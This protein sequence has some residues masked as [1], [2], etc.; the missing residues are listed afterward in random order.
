MTNA[1]RANNRT[2]HL[3]LELVKVTEMAALEASRWFGRGNADAAYQAATE[4]MFR[5]LE[6]L[7]IENMVVLT[8]ENSSY[9]NTN[10]KIGVAGSTEKDLII[11]PLESMEALAKGMP[12]AISVAALAGKNSLFS[13]NPVQ[14]I[15]R[16]AVG[17]AAK[18]VI[19]LNASLATNLNKVA[20]KL[21]KEISALNVAILNKQ[22]NRTTIETVRSLGAKV[23]LFDEGEIKLGLLVGLRGY[24]IDMLAGIASSTGTLISACAL[25]AMGGEMLARLAPQNPVEYT[26][27]IDANIDLER[28]LDLDTLVQ[29]QELYFA[30]TGITDSVLLAGVKYRGSGAFTHSLM[31]SSGTDVNLKHIKTEHNWNRLWQLVSNN[32]VTVVEDPSGF[33]IG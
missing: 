33:V 29:G 17:A 18:G 3:G 5:S 16:L 4:E 22:F 24:G 28:I 7:A 21:G 2:N 14:N 23:I 13:T 26:H 27:A 20:E 11:L 32:P 31:L 19:N 15:E 12:N 8:P 25:K 1:F 30:A 10:R 9:S 6:K